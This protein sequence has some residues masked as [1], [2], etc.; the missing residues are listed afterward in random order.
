MTFTTKDKSIPYQDSLVFVIFSM[1]A[2]V[3]TLGICGRK[4]ATEKYIC[5]FGKRPQHWSWY[6]RG[7]R[8]YLLVLLS[9]FPPR[10]M[11]LFNSFCRY[12]EGTRCKEDSKGRQ[13]W[14][15]RKHSE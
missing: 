6:E 15:R 2:R 1:L 12:Q 10:T 13:N 7:H 4:V 9:E 8:V 11:R 3:F 14:R 5:N